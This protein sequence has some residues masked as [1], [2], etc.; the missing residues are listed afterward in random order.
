MSINISYFL[1]VQINNLCNLQGLSF[2]D[3][4]SLLVNSN[5]TKSNA[6]TGRS[7]RRSSIRR[8][9]IVAWEGSHSDELNNLKVFTLYKSSRTKASF[10]FT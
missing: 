6:Y 1:Q 2:H 4:P 9:T 8:R 7:S 10:N 5:L 3:Y